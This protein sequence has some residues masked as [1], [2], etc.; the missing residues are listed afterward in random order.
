MCVYDEHP[1]AGREIQYRAPDSQSRYT[2][3]F[4][5]IKSNV[6]HLNNPGILND[7]LIS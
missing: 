5:E 7:P 3:P 2:T 1:L 6:H 4:N